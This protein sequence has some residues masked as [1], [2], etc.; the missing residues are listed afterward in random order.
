MLK[1]YEDIQSWLKLV[2]IYER[3]VKM[4]VWHAHTHIHFPIQ[5]EPFIKESIPA[6]SQSPSIQLNRP[7]RNPKKRTKLNPRSTRKPFLT[8]WAE[9]PSSMGDLPSP[10]VRRRTQ[11][12]NKCFNFMRPVWS[13]AGGPTKICVTHLGGDRTNR[14]NR[15]SRDPS[16]PVNSAL[17]PSDLTCLLT[18]WRGGKGRKKQKTDSLV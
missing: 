16:V 8:H 18:P 10:P 13:T 7:T 2:E 6:R 14:I 17:F 15:K 9:S 11:P 5:S 1:F 12:Q 4:L 3:V